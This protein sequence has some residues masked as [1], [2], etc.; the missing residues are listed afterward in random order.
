MEASLPCSHAHPSSPSSVLAQWYHPR[1][2]RMLRIGLKW[3]WLDKHDE[4]LQRKQ[5]EAVHC[6][7]SELEW[8]ER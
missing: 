5:K 7:R 1:A 6:W 8:A 2:A 3:K 4:H